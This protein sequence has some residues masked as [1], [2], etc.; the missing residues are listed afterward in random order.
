MKNSPW[1]FPVDFLWV[2][3]FTNL[4]ES[5]RNPTCNESTNGHS[6]S[7]T[8]SRWPKPNGRA[9]TKM[10]GAMSCLSGS[11]SMKNGGLKHETW[12]F[13]WSYM[14][15]IHVHSYMKLYIISARIWETLMWKN[16]DLSMFRSFD[17]TSWSWAQSLR[18]CHRKIWENHR[19]TNG[20]SG[21]WT[22]GLTLWYTFS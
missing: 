1:S 10:W 11:W 17:E 4:R 19:K 16:A 15:Y 6:H 9:V 21:G 13:K 7:V 2:F 12:A 3:F 8:V 18:K 22:L 20:E 14:D 5:T